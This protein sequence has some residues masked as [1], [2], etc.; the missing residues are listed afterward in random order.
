MSG[1]YGVETIRTDDG[2]V[3]ITCGELD[4]ANADG[5]FTAMA[6][7]VENHC[8]T[9]SIPSVIVDLCRVSFLSCAGVRAVLRLAERGAREDVAVRITVPDDG[10]VPRIVDVLAVRQHLP[11]VVCR[12]P[13]P[14]VAEPL[15]ECRSPGAVRPN[16]ALGRTKG[17]PGSNAQSPRTRIIDRAAPVA[18]RSR[19]DLEPR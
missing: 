3:L 7:A 12:V 2:L 8:G 5:W 6:D 19:G 4:A 18:G 10:P 16:D 15:R 9:T 1:Q 14:H 13:G 11:V 17:G